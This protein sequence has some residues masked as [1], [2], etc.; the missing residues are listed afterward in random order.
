MPRALDGH[1][2][3]YYFCLEEEALAG[4]RLPSRRGA[5]SLLAA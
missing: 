4:A 2:W 3:F 1:K 5:A